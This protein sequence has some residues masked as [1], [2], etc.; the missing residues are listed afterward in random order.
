MGEATT[1]LFV[2]TTTRADTVAERFAEAAFFVLCAAGLMFFAKVIGVGGPA[3][4]LD[5]LAALIV[6][7]RAVALVLFVAA[8]VAW[9][10]ALAARRRVVAPP[11]A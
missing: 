4:A 1:V 2:P 10:A 8:A 5:A 7:A 11:R 3:D 6:L 9:F